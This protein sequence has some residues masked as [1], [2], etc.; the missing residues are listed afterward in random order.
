MKI[1]NLNNKIYEA[2]EIS[3]VKD[4]DLRLPV[5]EIVVRDY[6]EVVGYAGRVRKPMVDWVTEYNYVSKE[7]L[8]QEQFD[9]KI[10]EA[11]HTPTGMI[12]YKK[13]KLTYGNGDIYYRHICKAVM[14]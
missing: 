13:H 2:L 4:G 9:E 8:T 1:D 3:V 11:G 5:D 7:N 10:K 14:F 6:D 12:S